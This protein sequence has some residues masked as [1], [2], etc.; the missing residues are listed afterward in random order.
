MWCTALFWVK[1]EC[2]PVPKKVMGRLFK[3]SHQ[4]S[5]L[6]ITSHVVAH[7]LHNQTLRDLGIYMYCI[8][9]NTP[10]GDEL[11]WFLN[12]GGGMHFQEFLSKIRPVHT[13]LGW[14]YYFHSYSTKSDHLSPSRKV[15]LSLFWRVRD[16]LTWY[17]YVHTHTQSGPY[18]CKQWFCN[19]S[20]AMC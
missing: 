17:I 2:T 12:E 8:V 9:E 7:C 6:S 5:L 18:V 14:L 16:G 20:F 10:T 4:H 3:P 11:K 1:R 19:A 13:Q 15:P